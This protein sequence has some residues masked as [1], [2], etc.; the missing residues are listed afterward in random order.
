[1]ASQLGNS[2]A[3]LVSWNNYNES[4]G[5]PYYGELDRPIMR[6]YRTAYDAATIGAA[7]EIHA[8]LK[9]KVAQ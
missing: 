1:M 4:L 8:L 9:D 5:N 2:R 3:S 7:E 6:A